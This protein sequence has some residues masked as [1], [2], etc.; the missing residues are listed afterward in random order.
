MRPLV[1]VV[2]LLTVLLAGCSSSAAVG[3]PQPPSAGPTGAAAAIPPT[4]LVLGDSV[5]F[6]TGASSP[7]TTGYAALVAGRLG[8]TVDNVAV[9]GATS[10][11]LVSA[12][13]P[14][15]VQTLRARGDRVRLVTLTIGGNDAFGTVTQVCTPNPAAAECISSVRAAIDGFGQ[16]LGTVLAALRGAAPAVP[17]AVT[18]YYNPLPGCD[19]ASYAPLAGVVLEGGPQLP[20]GLNDAIRRQAK[21]H[22]ATVV[23]TADT[24]RQPE[25]AGD[26]LHPNDA[27][28]AAIARAV[29]AAVAGKVSAA[30]AGTPPPG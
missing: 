5:A 26:C 19:L 12:Q 22:N 24:V 9:P 2:G 18:A 14:T 8:L 27:G 20:T 6:G 3:T 13:L 11:T 1:P 7:D 10:T 4:L 23:E 17:I 28:H 16:R 25:L 29:E 30:P 15:A 21:A